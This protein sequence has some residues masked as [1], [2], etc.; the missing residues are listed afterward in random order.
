MQGH[1]NNEYYEFDTVGLS[2]Q[3]KNHIKFKLTN[4]TVYDRKGDFIYPFQ[5][6]SDS[7]TVFGNQFNM[8][9]AYVLPFSYM[10]FSGTVTVISSYDQINYL[11]QNIG[12]YCKDYLLLNSNNKIIETN[13]ELTL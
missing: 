11:I 2:E 12:R 5:Y 3:I 1:I 7:S 8:A 9:Y 10:N 13:L 6:S 4:I